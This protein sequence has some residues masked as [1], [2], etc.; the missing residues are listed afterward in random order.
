MADDTQMAK[1]ILAHK[2]EFDDPAWDEVLYLLTMA[3]VYLLGLTLLSP[4]DLPWLHLAWPQRP[5]PP[6]P[7]AHLPWAH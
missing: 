2:W 6:L 3:M 1:S 4:R 7:R 5:W